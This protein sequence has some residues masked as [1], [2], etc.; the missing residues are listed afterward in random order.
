MTGAAAGDV[1]GS[2]QAKRF[3]SI[4]SQL[5]I[6]NQLSVE[7]TFQRRE[8]GSSYA[9]LSMVPAPGRHYLQYRSSWFQVE[10]TRE[11]A[12]V[13]LKSGTPWETVTIT[14]LA[15]DKNLLIQ[16]LEEAKQAALAAEEGKTVVYTSYGPEWRPFGSPRRRREIDSVVL[17]AGLS[18]FIVKDVK[19]FLGNGKWYH[20]RGIPYRRGYLLY[21][22]PG[23]GKTSFIQALAGHME[24]NICVMNLSERGMTDDRLAHL[25]TN[26]PPRS[27]ILLEDIDAAFAQRDPNEKQGFASMVTF[28]GLLNALDGVAASEERLVFM[29]TNHLE[30]L[31]PALIRPGR[32]DVKVLLDNVTE[33]QARTMFLKFYPGED[34]LA[35]QF[36]A[37]IFPNVAEASETIS[38]EDSI[39]S[40]NLAS[41]SPLPSRPS[42][43]PVTSSFD[44][45]ATSFASGP[46]I[47]WESI[48]EAG[49]EGSFFTSQPLENDGTG[50]ESVSNSLRSSAVSTG[51]SRPRD[52]RLANT[53][54]SSI[55]TIAE[56]QIHVGISDG[57]IRASEDIFNSEEQRIKD[58]IVRI[59]SQYLGDEG[60]HA[61]KMTLLDEANVKWYEREEQ[62]HEIRRIKKAILDGDW[63]EVDKLCSKPIMKNQKAFLYAMYKQQYLE[64]IDHHEIQKAFNHLTKRLKPLEHLA[65][66]PTEFRDICY[67]LTAKSVHDAPSFKT[68]EGIGPSREKL[69][70]HF[71]TMMDVEHTDDDGNTFIPPNRLLT[72]LR[73]AVAYQIEFSRY[74]PRIAPRITTL[75]QDYQTL[76]IPNAVKSTFVGH[77]GNIK[78]VE[79][80]GE[81]GR[82]IVSGS[83]D[84]TCRVWDTETAECVGVLEGHTSRIWELTSNKS[85]SIV[86]SASGDSTVKLWDMKDPKMPCVST[87][88]GGSG[89]I[90]SVKYHPNETHIA[91]AGYDKV[92]RLFDVERGTVVKTFTGH[93]LAVS[94]IIFSPLGNL[95]VSGSK[96]NTIKFW[97]IVSGLCIKTI[98][99]HLG[100]VTSVDMSSNGT[101]LLSSSKDNS[102]RLW[103]VR[104]VRPIRRFKG[105]QNTSKSFI[106]S[107]FAGDSLVVG[108]SEDGLVHVWDMEKGTLLS[109]LRGHQGIVY[110]AAYNKHQSLFAS[111]S[112]DRTLK[113]WWFDS[114]KPLFDV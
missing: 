32:V 23:T 39:M 65:T 17:N 20:E 45:R 22:P 51:T 107:S 84:N 54:S 41:T 44:A 105:H 86:A 56:N 59:L 91:S 26:S 37:Q 55:S 85:G 1:S 80:T 31:D 76:I 73:Q 25:L 113:T 28:S 79:F 71:Q 53:F 38:T 92:I 78:C 104:T 34:S 63:P 3:K 58:D 62:Q 24:Y 5:A 16:M 108:G 60:F 103:D 8:N 52:T 50:N 81:E 15:R 90:Y 12:M 94:K 29:T 66:T 77:K 2:A 97:D 102:N 48:S 47:S 11:R 46:R 57:Y 7:T 95:I 96:D 98:A 68:W 75:L 82:K 36:V 27:L 6:S 42:S 64:Y 9:R 10:R 61:T 110:S 106:R 4:L 74:H 111:C 30:R 93:Q 33:A 40:N 101:L 112:D 87:L 100:E 14:A 49:V 88:V 72:L 99:S 114:G 21:G 35:D 69:A 70:E 109:R 43:A 13:D 18:D 19:N 89:D 83:S 67:L